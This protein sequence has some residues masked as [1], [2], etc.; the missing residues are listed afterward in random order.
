MQLFLLSVLFIGLSG[1][2]GSGMEPPDNGEEDL[3]GADVET[4]A[5]KDLV[6]ASPW[7]YTFKTDGIT[8]QSVLDFK[9]LKGKMAVRVYRMKAGTR[10]RLE[11]DCGKGRW[12]VDSDVLRISACGLSMKASYQPVIDGVAKLCDLSDEDDCAVMRSFAVDAD[13]K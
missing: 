7:C 11:E 5:N 9:D 2:G 1:C 3:T 12:G 8:F 6:S 10:G 4:Q 13:C